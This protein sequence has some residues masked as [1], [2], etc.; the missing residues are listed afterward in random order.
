MMTILFRCQ[1]VKGTFLFK[2]L[3]PKWRPYPHFLRSYP[4]YELAICNVFFV[5]DCFY[6]WPP[7][8][9]VQLQYSSMNYR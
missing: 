7:G 6:L 8:G 2:I 4:A 1:Y 9:N 5:F 3:M